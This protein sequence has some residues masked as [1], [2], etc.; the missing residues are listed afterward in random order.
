MR[1]GQV[2]MLL[3]FALGISVGQ[4]LLKIAAD[5]I[6]AYQGERVLLQAALNPY[7]I[8][9]CAVYLVTM[10][11]WVWILGGMHL[12][13]A[14]PFLV[15]GFVFTPLLAVVFLGE[16]ITKGYLL[17]TGLVLAGLYFILQ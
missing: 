1:Y 5:Q 14:Y 12:S 10:V 16:P 4:V 17:G 11:A 3:A 8:G 9:A 2:L 7:L 13:R 6:A 15:L